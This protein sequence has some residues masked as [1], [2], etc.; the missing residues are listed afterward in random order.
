MGG[1]I[2]K[3]FLYLRQEPI[4]AHTLKVLEAC[5]EIHSIILVVPKE[6]KSFCENRIVHAGGFVKVTSVIPGGPK[7]QD[8]VFAGLNGMEEKPE[9]VI[10]HDGVRPLVTEELIR[11]TIALAAEGTSAIVGVPVHNTIKSVDETGR[12]VKTLERERIWSIQTPQAFPCD[13]LLK[14][15]KEAYR[16]GYYGTDDASL[17]ERIGAPVRVLMGSHE[18]IKITSPTDLAMGEVLLRMRPDHANRARV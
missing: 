17:V 7:R 2:R 5:S 12:I 1:T 4:L 15:Y 10:I 13:V 8:S 18:N 6:E 9:I 14:A 3:Q 16:T 11:K